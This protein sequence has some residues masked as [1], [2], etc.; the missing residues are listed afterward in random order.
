MR[1]TPQEDPEVT[2]A[3]L[4]EWAHHVESVLR[5]LAHALNNRAA[6]LSAVIELSSE[7]DDDPAATRGILVEEMSRV[8]DL[9]KVVRAIGVP[10]SGIE[11]IVPADLAPEIQ[12]IMALHADLKDRAVKVD[13]ASAP[14]VRVAR[15]MFTRALVSLAASA[16]APAG[17]RTVTLTLGQE[18]DWLVARAPGAKSGYAGELARAMGGEP[19]GDA[20]GFRIPT[21]E[22]V[23]RR[24]AR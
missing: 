12:S 2:A 14:V 17:E 18:G 19:L 13:A 10:R 15:W 16:T 8:Q 7:P 11:A 20:S 4:R 22:A 6:A 24:E 21:L 9:V 3:S 5:G 1:T 23:R